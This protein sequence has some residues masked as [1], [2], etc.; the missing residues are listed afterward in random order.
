M[1]IVK[2]ID[3]IVLAQMSIGY[4]KPTLNLDNLISRFT[5]NR[6]GLLHTNFH[7]Q[8][9]YYLENKITQTF[10]EWRE[11]FTTTTLFRTLRKFLQM[12][13]KV[14]LQYLA[15]FKISLGHP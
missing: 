12:R 11:I 14:A 7:N 15:S 1:N 5:G 3:I 10:E 8:D 2:Q 13:I 9:V 4:S 6:C